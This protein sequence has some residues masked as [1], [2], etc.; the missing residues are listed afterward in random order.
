MTNGNVAP[1]MMTRRE[2]AAVVYRELKES[3]RAAFD[4]AA[5]YGRWLI[6]S[7]SSSMEPRYSG[8]F[9]SRTV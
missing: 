8:C 3:Q 5:A 2:A 6:A 7:C 4:V 1:Q 9:R